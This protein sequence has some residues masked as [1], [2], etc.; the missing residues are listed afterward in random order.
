[1]VT[2]SGRMMLAN[3]SAEELVTTSPKPESFAALLIAEMMLSANSTVVA[4]AVR[5]YAHRAALLSKRRT[6]GG[7]L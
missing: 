1:M 4:A 3:T 2:V 5:D 6:D 7:Q